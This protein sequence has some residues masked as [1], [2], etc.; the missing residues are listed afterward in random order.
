MPNNG[1]QPR[2][3][4]GFGVPLKFVSFGWQLAPD[5]VSAAVEASTKAAALN[6]GVATSDDS[7]GISCKT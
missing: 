7:S 3:S 6:V 2:V 1:A 4:K 5:A